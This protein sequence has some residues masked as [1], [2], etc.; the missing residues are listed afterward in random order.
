MS[1]SSPGLTRPVNQAIGRPMITPSA[2]PPSTSQAPWR[3]I[4]PEAS[5][6][7]T[8]CAVTRS[9][10]NS[11]TPQASSMATTPRTVSVKGPFA[12]AS[13]TTSRVAAGAL[14]GATAPSS[15]ASGSGNPNRSSAAVTVAEAA[16]TSASE[17]LNTVWPV[18]RSFLPR[19]RSPSWK[20][21]TLRAMRA[22]SGNQA[23]ASMGIRSST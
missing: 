5:W 22:V 20:P 11:M 12:F 8:A 3:R 10:L 9:T 23:D 18:S 13:R 2:I 17:T 1:V 14:A 19:N 6:P 7:V 4:D 16:T 21:T 15:R